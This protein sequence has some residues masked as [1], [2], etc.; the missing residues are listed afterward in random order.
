M[1][2]H[3]LRKD[4]NVQLNLPYAV[5]PSLTS[6]GGPKAMVLEHSCL[7]GTRDCVGLSSA[8]RVL[9]RKDPRSSFHR[10]PPRMSKKHTA[11]DRAAIEAIRLAYITTLFPDETNRPK[12]KAGRD[13]FIAKHHFPPGLVMKFQKLPY[14]LPDNVLMEHKVNPEGMRALGTLLAEPHPCAKSLMVVPNYPREETK[15]DLQILLSNE[16]R[17]RLYQA[18]QRLKKSNSSGSLGRLLRQNSSSSLGKP[19]T[20]TVEDEDDPTEATFGMDS[21]SSFTSPTADM[22]LWYEQSR[23]IA[24]PPTPLVRPY[25]EEDNDD[26]DDNDMILGDAPGGMART[27]PPELPNAESIRACDKA[28]F[29]EELRNAPLSELTFLRQTD[30]QRPNTPASTEY[31]QDEIFGFLKCAN[32]RRIPDRKAVAKNSEFKHL[33]LHQQ[34]LT[35]RPITGIFSVS[36]APVELKEDNK[37][38]SKEEFPSSV[39]VL[40]TLA[41]LASP[42]SDD[43]PDS[44]C[45]REEVVPDADEESGEDKPS[46][47]VAVDTRA[48]I[49]SIDI[50]RASV[51]RGSS[52]SM[53][54]C[55]WDGNESG[56]SGSKNIFSRRQQ[57][58]LEINPGYESEG[59]LTLPEALEN[60]G[61]NA[62]PSHGQKILSA[63]ICKVPSSTGRIAHSFPSTIEHTSLCARDRSSLPGR[64][65]SVSTLESNNSQETKSH[66]EKSGVEKGITS[67]LTRKEVE[68]PNPFKL[69]DTETYPHSN[70]ENTTQG[71]M[72]DANST[73]SSYGTDTGKAIMDEFGLNSFDRNDAR[74]FDLLSSSGHLADVLGGEFL[75]PELSTTEQKQGT[76]PDPVPQEDTSD[77]STDS[78]KSVLSSG[79]PYNP[80]ESTGK[81]ENAT[82]DVP[83][84]VLV[85][86]LETSHLNTLLGDGNDDDSDF[87]EKW[88]KVNKRKG[89]A[90]SSAPAPFSK[91]NP[92]PHDTHIMHSKMTGNRSE[93]KPSSP[94][95]NAL[96]LAVKA[97]HL[98]KRGIAPRPAS[99]NEMPSQSDRSNGENNSNAIDAVANHL[100]DDF[101]DNK[102]EIHVL[103]LRRSGHDWDASDVSSSSSSSSSDDS[104]DDSSEELESLPDSDKGYLCNSKEDGEQA[105]CYT[106]FD[107]VSPIDNYELS[108]QAKPSSV[109]V[110][111]G[112]MVERPQVNTIQ[113]K[114]PKTDSSSCAF[115]EMPRQSGQSKISTASALDEVTPEQ[116]K[117]QKDREDAIGPTDSKK[118]AD[119]TELDF[120]QSTRGASTDE[121]SEY[122][123]SNSRNDTLTAEDTTEGSHAANNLSNPEEQEELAYLEMLTVEED[124]RHEWFATMQK[125]LEADYQV[126]VQVLATMKYEADQVDRLMDYSH[127]A[128]DI[129]TKTIAEVCTDPVLVAV[130]GSGNEMMKALMTSYKAL[131]SR[132]EESLPGLEASVQEMASYKSELNRSVRVIRDRGYSIVQDLSSSE[133]A[134]RMSWAALEAS[135]LRLPDDSSSSRSKDRW[136]EEVDY[137]Q[138]VA[139]HLSLW[140]ERT[141]DLKNLTVCILEMECECHRRLKD[142]LLGFLPKRHNLFVGVCDLLDPAVDAFETSA[143]LL[144]MGEVDKR[145]EHAVLHFQPE[146]KRSILSLV[147]SSSAAYE[148]RPSVPRLGDFA[149]LAAE[150]TMIEKKSE[151]LLSYS[152]I[153]SQEEDEWVKI[154]VVI[155]RQHYLHRYL[156][157][158]DILASLDGAPDDEMEGAARVALEKGTPLDSIA[159][160]SCDFEQRGEYLE[161]RYENETLET[162]DETTE[163]VLNLQF[164]TQEEA[165]QWLS[166]ANDLFDPVKDTVEQKQENAPALQIVRV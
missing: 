30:P 39:S 20:L 43:E 46:G 4:S 163:R 70:T 3:S 52:R 141:T 126:Y 150:D 113:C 166:E 122:S 27:S 127:Q 116:T 92:N 107:G 36:Y 159:L 161:V 26:D 47:S 94:V 28:A 137:R 74:G 108:T 110:S 65:V 53:S 58:T 132:F 97:P 145:L 16:E 60:T 75:F 138:A 67:L 156:L 93:K 140:R 15:R 109:P 32:V 40:S 56:T 117:S 41:A 82:S 10:V 66:H 86:V 162:E 151:N 21:F 68:T 33:I 155:T 55:S 63:K 157:S 62:T 118:S 149:S 119:A 49:K 104:S 81:P 79:K 18:R 29:K 115:K 89:V 121:D 48:P 136:L 14:T 5:S 103:E 99:S 129:Y 146:K 165:S 51:V 44:V 54:S 131:S 31:L 120:S 128:I 64:L 152:F 158:A 57:S 160:I 148:K 142:I 144:E 139:R 25:L 61:V 114:E 164:A 112:E 59:A 85:T 143:L 105:M 72:T 2:L 42:S 134:V 73:P 38:T 124:E 133:D 147:S 19:L 7:C 69:R 90:A 106:H 102:H 125:T 123:Q 98:L 100:E 83:S 76:I 12:L 1:S 71:Y 135:S 23:R 77:S 50:F 6:K 111:L 96:L 84:G 154:M 13:Y 24:L 34:T 153:K 88:E 130:M 45:N 17:L 91:P 11:Q 101:G 9:G 22:D 8:F 87:E 80:A 37:T 78:N 95:E 35:R